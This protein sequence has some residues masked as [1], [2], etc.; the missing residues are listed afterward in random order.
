MWRKKWNKKQV[1][2]QAQIKSMND[3][4]SSTKKFYNKIFPQFAMFK[5]KCRDENAV[6]HIQIAK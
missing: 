3:R 4:E 6:V 5:I 2:Q 1:K